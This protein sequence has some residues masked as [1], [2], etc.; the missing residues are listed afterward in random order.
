MKIFFDNIVNNNTG[1]NTF[2][3]RLAHQLALMGHVLADYDDYDVQLAFIEA[4]NQPK[5][6]KPLVQRLDGIWFK[7]DEFEHRNNAIMDTWSK[8]QAVVWQSEFDR[9]MT[10]HHWGDHRGA[11]IH[12]GIDLSKR[13]TEHRVPAVEALRRD[14]DHFFVCSSNWHP[15]KRLNTNVQLFQHVRD[16]LPGR[17]CLVVIGNGAASMI[18]DPDVFY[19]GSVPEEIYLEIYSTADWMLHLAW[20][21]HCPNVVVECLSQGTPVICTNSGGTSELV[22]DFGIVLREETYK[23]ELTNYDDPPPIEISQLDPLTLLTKPIGHHANIDIV[24]TAHEY[25]SLFEKLLKEY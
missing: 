6:G 3:R 22:K 11:V 1:P 4:K 12:N 13:I 5:A 24:A 14:Y 18:A 19:A 9:N 23:F 20:L 15:Q 2:A 16:S 7:P 25:V 8:A 17:S 21:D 10:T